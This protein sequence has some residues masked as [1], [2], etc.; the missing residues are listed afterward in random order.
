[1]LASTNYIRSETVNRGERRIYRR[2]TWLSERVSKEELSC[3]SCHG[4][5]KTGEKYAVTINLSRLCKH[6]YADMPESVALASIGFEGM[7]CVSCV[8]RFYRDIAIYDFGD[9]AVIINESGCE[10]RFRDVSEAQA[11][12]DATYAMSGLMIGALA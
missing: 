3:G 4:E 8:A 5:I 10:Y 12:V 11:F 2:H 1:M 6:C 9:A 7:K